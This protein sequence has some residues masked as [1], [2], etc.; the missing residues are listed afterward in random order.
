MTTR[1]EVGEACGLHSVRRMLAANVDAVVNLVHTDGA[2]AVV[3]CAP[4]T[5]RWIIN[6]P[7]SRQTS[8]RGRLDDIRAGLADLV[9]Q[10]RRLEIGSIAI[11][12][13]GADLCGVD[14]RDLRP[15]IVDACGAVPEVRLLLFAPTVTAPA[16]A[17]SRPP[18]RGRASRA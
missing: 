14:W 11:P 5:P 12:A 10:I 4:R 13:L 8:Q 16:S 15:L 2:L 17:R 9:D 7:A 18:D 6:F 1:R 3:D